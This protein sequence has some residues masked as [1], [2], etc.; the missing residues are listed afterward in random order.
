MDKGSELRRDGDWAVLRIWGE[1]DLSWSQDVRRQVLE[2]YAKVKSR[3]RLEPFALDILSDVYYRDID[4][5]GIPI[6]NPFIPAAVAAA[7]A[8]ANSDADPTN[9]VDAINGRRRQ[10]DVFDRSN[11]V[12]RDTWR[13]VAGLKGELGRFKWDASYV[14]G[15]LRDYNASEDIDNNRYRNALNAIRVGPGNVVGV[16]IVC[17]DAAARAAKSR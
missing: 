4:P 11:V 8:A 13:V 9:D 1:V 3:S 15:H 14:Y 16:D 2:A 17:A 12:S 5:Y 7:I 10:N 6:T